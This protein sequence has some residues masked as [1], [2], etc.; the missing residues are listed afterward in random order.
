MYTKINNFVYT[1]YCQIL[2]ARNSEQPILM[3]V[4]HTHFLHQYVKHC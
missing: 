3:I 4:G 1:N 2:T